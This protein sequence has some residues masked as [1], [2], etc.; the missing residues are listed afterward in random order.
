MKTF[1]VLLLSALVMSSCQQTEPLVE[2]SKTARLSAQ[3]LPIGDGRITNYPSR[4]NVFSCQQSFPNI[5]GAFQNG[6][7]L[8]TNGTFDITAKPIVDGNV[9]WSGWIWIRPE[10]PQNVLHIQSN[11]LPNHP[12]GKFPIDWWDDAFA[13]DRNPNLIK[14]RWWDINMPPIPIMLPYAKCVPSGPIGMMY[15]GAV[16]YN[17]LDGQGKDAVAHEIQ[18]GCQGHPSERQE[19]HYHNLSRCLDDSGWGHSKQ[20]GVAFDGFGIFGHKGENGQDVTNYDLDE[21]HGHAHWVPWGP[22]WQWLYHYH[23]TREYPYTIGCF[24]GNMVPGTQN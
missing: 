22:Q 6:P 11:G 24:R 3:A 4:G 5:G 1:A 20:L 17:A 19:Y 21:C 16:L 13:F 23:A 2:E 8:K 10:F 9:L 12:T 15:S 14:S 18:D 7:W